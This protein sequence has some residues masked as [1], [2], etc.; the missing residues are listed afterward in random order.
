MKQR[1]QGRGYR[2]KRIMRD[3]EIQPA[4]NAN[5]DPTLLHI[6]LGPD[7]EFYASQGFAIALANALTDCVETGTPTKYFRSRRGKPSEET[8][9]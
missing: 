6:R 8:D 3:W 2:D 9:P 1:P 4:C 5:S 7:F